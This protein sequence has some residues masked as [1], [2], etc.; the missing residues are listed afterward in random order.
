MEREDEYE[1]D[2]KFG[3]WYDL[4]LDHLRLLGWDGPV[5]LESAWL[6]YQEGET[7]E[8]AARKLYD[9]LMS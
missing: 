3:E 4:Y 2:D 1:E 5:G 8:D 7:P 9:E 6:Y